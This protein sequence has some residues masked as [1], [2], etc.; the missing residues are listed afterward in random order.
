MAMR[1]QFGDFQE[2]DAWLLFRLDTQ[3]KDQAIDVYMLMD[4]PNG[5]ILGH[6]AVPDERLSPEQAAKLLDGG[7]SR[8]G[9]RP[10]RLLLVKGDPAEDVFR[11]C[12]T[13]LDMM[14]ETVPAP[15]VE[16]LLA[17]VKESFGQQF[18]SP[19]SMGY[20]GLRDDADD[21][22]RESARRLVPDSYDPCSCGSG[23]KFKFCCKPI[24][25][26]IIGAM[27]AAEQGRR[28]EALQWIAKAKA[29]AGETAEVL[30]REAIVH[31]FFDRAKSDA[32]LSK[33]LEV[34]PDHP[35]ANYIR[36]IVLKE[37]NDLP[38]A[39]AAYERAIASYPK[40]DRYHLNETYNNLG[41]ALYESGQ[42]GAA[43]RAWEQALVLLP[44]DKTVRANLVEFIY[45]NRD[46][47][48]ELREV[49]PFVR[50]FFER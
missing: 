3:V 21:L 45:E 23:K 31:S 33:C 37:R 28:A 10:R 34:D 9:T 27:A 8:K 30:C 4:L 1:Y 25:R 15:H 41:T 2:N 43:K 20:A 44:S 35:R 22:D 49:S 18:F 17:P 46:V 32:A 14:F 6:E 13:K 48:K 38:G 11:A 39:I 50:K 40:T 29:V 24:F 19:S 16:D 36:G 5:V 42:F 26:E 47:P 7:R 12:C